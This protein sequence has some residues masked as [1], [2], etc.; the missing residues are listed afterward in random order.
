MGPDRVPPNRRR[1]DVPIASREQSGR[2]RSVERQYRQTGNEVRRAWI[3]AAIVIVS[4]LLTTVLLLAISGQIRDTTAADLIAQSPAPLPE[5]LATQATPRPSVSPSPD[6]E[7]TPSAQPS[8]ANATPAQQEATPASVGELDDTEIQAAVDKKLE[9]DPRL[10][11]LG[12]TATV[13]DG[14]VILV[15]TAPSDEMK[16]KVEKLVRA[17][18][19]VKQIDNQI[20]VISNV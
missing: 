11:L 13:S 20:V 9:D 15:G 16:S 19:G 1:I 6:H 18:K 8:R 5:Q 12:I 17:I 4:T 14:K 7:P 2:G 10:S 3:D